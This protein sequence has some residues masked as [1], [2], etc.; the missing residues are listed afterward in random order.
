MADGGDLQKAKEFNNVISPYF[1]EIPLDQVILF[2]LHKG[3]ILTTLM[4]IGHPT[5]PPYK[6]W[7]FLPPLHS[8][9]DGM[10]QVGLAAGCSAWERR[11]SCRTFF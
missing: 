1:F 2:Q 10:S 11:G 3:T 9:G 5:W 6:P 8:T 7:H 4:C